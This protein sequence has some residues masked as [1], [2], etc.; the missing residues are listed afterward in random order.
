MLRAFIRRKT[1]KQC[2]LS[3]ALGTLFLCLGDVAELFASEI[4]P[5]YFGASPDALTDKEQNDE[6]QRL[7]KYKLWG[8]GISGDA[9][10]VANK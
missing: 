10:G 1:M 3:F 7:I 8:T 5:F 9:Y 2:K 4:T 6:W